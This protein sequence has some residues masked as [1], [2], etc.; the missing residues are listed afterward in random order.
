MIMHTIFTIG[1]NYNNRR[2]DNH[3]VIEYQLLYNYKI[4]NVY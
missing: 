4:Q 1:Q 2:T 3:D